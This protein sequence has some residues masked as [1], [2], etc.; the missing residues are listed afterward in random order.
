MAFLRL[1]VLVLATSTFA[2]CEEAG[3]P[4]G[5]PGKGG[6]GGKGKGGH[7]GHKPWHHH[8][9]VKSTPTVKTVGD[10]TG[11]ILG[12]QL[13]AQSNYDA[14]NRE[15]I[16]RAT[17]AA[18][19]TSAA[20]DGLLEEDAIGDDG[21]V[22]I[23]SAMADSM[24]DAME[25]EMEDFVPAPRAAAGTNSTPNVRF[26]EST[27]TGSALTSS[28]T[29][30]T[31]VTDSGYSPARETDSAPPNRTETATAAG[32]VVD[33]K[34]ATTAPLFISMGSAPQPVKAAEIQKTVSA[35]AIKSQ[36][37][38]K[39][40]G[41]S[42]YSASDAATRASSTSL[43]THPSRENRALMLAQA[44]ARPKAQMPGK[45][46]VKS[47]QRK[48]RFPD[49]VKA[50][51]IRLTKPEP[52][53]TAA[54]LEPVASLKSETDSPSIDE[55]EE[56]FDLNWTLVLALG[57]SMVAA[58][59][60][61]LFWKRQPATTSVQVMVPATGEHFTIRTTDTEGEYVL[62]IKDVRG[63]LLRSAGTLRAHSVARAAVLPP[64][65]AAELGAQG[66]FD[67]FE[68]TE[69]GRFVR[70]EKDEGYQIFP[71]VLA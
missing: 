60:A 27:D 47:A 70:T 37:H 49:P 22:A 58:S 17:A 12:Q 42:G 53:R 21:W 1:L 63:N 8:N 56:E 48:T 69:E 57:L 3:G 19:E 9:T 39:P 65:L 18:L 32:Q 31:P 26:A 34:S 30:R 45:E 52:S 54:S 29:A 36:S 61:S 62:D 11:Q 4:A 51:F 5:A 41:L 44:L 67:R 6:K 25:E 35:P 46:P 13:N 59:L 20:V 10:L 50:L 64:S 28:A 7:H 23:K 55:T 38:P 68:L 33:L 15:Q 24:E 14:A 16:N 43:A 40:I 2:F 71:F 66:S